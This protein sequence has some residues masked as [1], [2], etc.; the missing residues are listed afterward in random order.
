MGAGPGGLESSWHSRFAPSRDP[1]VMGLVSVP[2][3]QWHWEHKNPFTT[4][5]LVAQQDKVSPV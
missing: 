1:Q 4:K 5:E 3:L 2:D